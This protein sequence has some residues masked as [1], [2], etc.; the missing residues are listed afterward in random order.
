MIWKDREIKTGGDMMNVVIEI[1]RSNNRAEAQEFMRLYEIITPHARDN[2]GYMAGYYS[3]EEADQIYDLFGVSH[4]IFGKTHPNAEEAFRAGCR[5][6]QLTKDGM[7]I[8]RAVETVREGSEWLGI[9]E[10]EA[11]RDIV[12]RNLET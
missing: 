6:G 8:Q 1:C 9:A 2:I 11:I 10:R 3:P 7:D 5:L 4:P 12:K